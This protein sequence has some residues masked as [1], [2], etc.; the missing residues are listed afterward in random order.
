MLRPD[1]RTLVAIENL[2]GRFDSEGNLMQLQGYLADISE[3]KQTELALR[4][5]DA[6]NRALL[7]AIP[8]L[9]FRLDQSGTILHFP[10]SHEDDPIFPPT[11]FVGQHISNLLPSDLAE[12]TMSHAELALRTRELQ[13]YAFSLPVT[14]KMKAYE[15][16]IVTCGDDEVLVIL[17]NVTDLRRTEVALRHLAERLTRAQEEERRRI[18]RELHDEAGQALTAITMRLQ[19][20]EQQLLKMGSVPSEVRQGVFDLR[21]VVKSTQQRLRT[22]AH[23]LH[24]SV[25]EHLGL[26]E[27]LHS[28]LSETSSTTNTNISVSIP[29]DFPRF[30][31]P[32]ETALYRIVQE[33]VGNS[34]KH[35]SSQSLSLSC[36]VGKG[37]VTLMVADDGSGFDPANLE[38]KH[39]IGLTS[40]RERAEMIGAR[41]DIRSAKGQGTQI[42]VYLP[43]RAPEQT[44]D[45]LVLLLQE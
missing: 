18:S 40:M 23:A 25:L 35:S 33:A 36:L 10:S 4:K 38:A 17:R 11:G 9:M 44:H 24:P 20:F 39:A 7:S 43:D 19:L 29:D 6:E 37:G 26:T 21:A 32:T 3:L 2:V 30:A 12:L 45:T 41:L 8:D 14:D 28:F 16:R 27:A 1:G 42:S 22:L 5:S 34:L 13:T 31:L 15:A